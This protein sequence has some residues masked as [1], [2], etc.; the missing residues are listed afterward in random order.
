MLR[1]L[2]PV[3]AVCLSPSRGLRR[4]LVVGAARAL[5]V[6][7][8]VLG[9]VLLATAEPGSVGHI[10][11]CPV[12]EL[13]GL[14]CPGCGSLRSVRSLIDGELAQAWQYNPLMLAVT[15][16]VLALVWRAS[17]TKPGRAVVRPGYIYTLLVLV[18]AFGVARNLPLY[19][20]LTPH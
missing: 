19:A 11:A 15:P 6:P 1:S 4:S 3:D 9:L 5:V 10:L 17:L 2:S 8:L 18:I 12:R 7:G 16:L 20:C 13:T 14:Y